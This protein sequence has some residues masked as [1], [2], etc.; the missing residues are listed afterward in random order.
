MPPDCSA[1]MAEPVR[2]RQQ[3]QL[4]AETVDDMNVKNMTE[5]MEL[6]LRIYQLQ[7]QAGETAPPTPR[8]CDDITSVTRSVLRIIVE[9]AG[10]TS[11]M[12]GTSHHQNQYLPN[13]QQPSSL[14]SPFP[15]EIL[16]PQEAKGNLDFRLRRQTIESAVYPDDNGRGESSACCSSSIDSGIFLL[17]LACYQRL[18]DLFKHVCLSIH[19]HIE[20]ED[21]MASSTAQVVMTTELISH[22][23]GRLD[24]G[25]HQLISQMSPPT[26]SSPSTSIPNIWSATGGR[27]SSS[28]SS[29]DDF[30]D[31]GRGVMTGA[32]R[33]SRETSYSGSNGS[34]LSCSQGITSV[35]NSMA[36]RQTALRAH[37]GFIKDSIQKSDKI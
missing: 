34:G 1:P 5:M 23:I 37:I 17:I 16:S 3:Q 24:R 6:N 8:L 14:P 25:L 11:S 22:L 28:S 29:Y 27:C 10:G 15:S 2:H 26:T 36:R 20:E 21:S 33:N 13:K 18:I 4:H 19:T 30:F 31:V 35:V 7:A 32:G 12:R 9:G